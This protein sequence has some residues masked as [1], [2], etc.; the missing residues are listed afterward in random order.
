MLTARKFFMYPDKCSYWG[1]WVKCVSRYFELTLRNRA[2]LGGR[3]TESVLMK[4][5][6]LSTLGMV[7][8]SDKKSQYIVCYTA[9]W[10]WG[11]GY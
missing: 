1:I 11:T 4:E 3:E 5:N 6:L 10:G 7:V 8:E 2:G 9:G